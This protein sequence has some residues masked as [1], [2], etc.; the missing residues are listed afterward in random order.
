MKLFFWVKSGLSLTKI[1]DPLYSSFIVVIYSRYFRCVHMR[2]CAHLS[3]I[4]TVLPL[5]DEV[6]CSRGNSK[7][8]GL[9]KTY[10]PNDQNLAKTDY[11]AYLIKTAPI[12]RTSDHWHSVMGRWKKYVTLKNWN[13]IPPPPNRVTN[14]LFFTA[15]WQVFRPPPLR[16]V[17]Y[18]CIAPI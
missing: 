4:F 8:T 18:F 16:S 3:M 14:G 17:T 2:P 13:F 1:N 5:D 11:F 10:P 9:L 12:P 6:I 15:K 7:R